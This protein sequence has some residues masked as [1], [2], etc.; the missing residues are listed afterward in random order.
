MRFGELKNVL[1]KHNLFVSRGITVLHYFLKRITEFIISEQIIKYFIFYSFSGKDSVKNKQFR[2]LL[3]A[4]N[5]GDSCWN[6][7][8]TLSRTFVMQSISEEVIEYKMDTGCEPYGN[9]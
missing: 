9:T 7:G 8:E 4:C 6:I 5:R 3:P 1:L 2:E